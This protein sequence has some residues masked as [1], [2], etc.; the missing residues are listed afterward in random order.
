MENTIS[1]IQWLKNISN[2]KLYRFLHFDKRFFTY[3]HEAI[4]FAKEFM[5]ITTKDVEVIFHAQ[6]SVL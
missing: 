1:V 5:P 3:L 2:K 6:K 4:Q